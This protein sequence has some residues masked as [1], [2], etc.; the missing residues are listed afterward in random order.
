M[1]EI[2][3]YEHHHSKREIDVMIEEFKRLDRAFYETDG[4]DDALGARVR[5]T[6]ANLENAGVSRNVLRSID[7]AIYDEFIDWSKV[8]EKY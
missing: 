3:Q 4:T 2:K 7:D 8:E 6:I 5:E 1:S